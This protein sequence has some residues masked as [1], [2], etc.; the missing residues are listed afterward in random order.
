MTTRDMLQRLRRRGVGLLVVLA[1]AC[2]PPAA[3]P[4]PVGPASPCADASYASLRQQPPDSL[5]AR[6]W[7]RL[8]ALDRECTLARAQATRDANG[9][10]GAR[11]WMMAGIAT[12][13]M[14]AMAVR[15]W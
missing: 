10:M 7:Q 4:A 2:V 9:M 12:V 13:M 15:M 5:S 1:A 6:E 8:Q 3:R 14:L 11:H